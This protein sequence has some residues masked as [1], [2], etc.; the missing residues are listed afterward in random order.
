MFELYKE[1]KSKELPSLISKKWTEGFNFRGVFIRMMPYS[2]S[3]FI[4]QEMKALKYMENELRELEF[5]QNND[6]PTM[7][8]QYSGHQAPSIF[9]KLIVPLLNGIECG[10]F[11]LFAS[12][13][14]YIENYDEVDVNDPDDELGR[15]EENV[16]PNDMPTSK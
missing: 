16:E 14:I 15:R 10:G 9:Q 6:R 1:L 7:F 4:R 12:P 11:F 5:I 13:T 3:Y 8:S 2:D